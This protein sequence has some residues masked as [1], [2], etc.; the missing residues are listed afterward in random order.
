MRPLPGK[1]LRGRGDEFARHGRVKTAGIFE[2]LWRPANPEIGHDAARDG[3]EQN[4]TQ[5]EEERQVHVTMMPPAPFRR[6]TV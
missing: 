2:R 6:H 4:N 1:R 5:N 3:R